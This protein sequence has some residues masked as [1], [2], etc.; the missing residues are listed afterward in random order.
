MA[1][2]VEEVTDE[3]YEAFK[4][5]PATVVVY[6][7]ASCEP[8]AAYDPV[9]ADIARQF[10]RVLV[11]KARM[12]VPGRCREIKKQHNFETYPTTHL[13]ARGNLLLTREGKV[14]EDELSALI[15]RYF[16]HVSDDASQPFADCKLT[17]ALSRDV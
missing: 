9:V 12:H 17:S 3:N 16:P 2:T 7:I 13:Y 4:K 15:Q 6:G 14:E 1:G 10:P 8:C 11:G 5:A